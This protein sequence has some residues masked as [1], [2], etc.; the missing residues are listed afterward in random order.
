MSF[1]Y[2]VA[3]VNKARFVTAAAIDHPSSSSVSRVIFSLI[4][5][6]TLGTVENLMLVSLSV[7]PLNNLLALWDQSLLYCM[8]NM[9]SVYPDEKKSCGPNI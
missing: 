2:Y 6:T 3:S 7:Q 1:Y 4:S 5:L 9:G 8:E